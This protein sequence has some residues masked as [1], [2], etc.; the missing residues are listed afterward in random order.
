VIVEDYWLVVP[1]TTSEGTQ[2]LTVRLVGHEETV[3][4]IELMVVDQ[5][6]AMERWLRI[7]GK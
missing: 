1:S 4:I 3:T 2:E 5:E 7:A 6:E